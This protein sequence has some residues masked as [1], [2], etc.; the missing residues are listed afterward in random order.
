MCRGCLNCICNEIFLEKQTWNGLLKVVAI[1]NI[2]CYLSLF[3]MYIFVLFNDKV[4]IHLHILYCLDLNCLWWRKKFVMLTQSW[5]ILWFKDQGNRLNYS[6]MK[7]ELL[8]NISQVEYYATMKDL[9][10]QRASCCFWNWHR[11]NF[12]SSGNT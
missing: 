9:N 1:Q 4:N 12:I 6:R 2:F 3:I 10:S 8:F 5:M 11:F 7:I